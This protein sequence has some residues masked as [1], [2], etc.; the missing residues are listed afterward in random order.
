MDGC[1]RRNPWRVIPLG[2]FVIAVG[3]LRA[4]RGYYAPVEIAFESA[5][6]IGGALWLF[7]YGYYSRICVSPEG[8]R[9]TD[10]FGER[11]SI[12]FKD[13]TA[14]GAYTRHGGKAVNE[15]LQIAWATDGVEVNMNNY[16]RRDMRRLV[17]AIVD[18]TPQV[19]I[20]QSLSDFGLR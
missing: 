13:L 20:A 10:L 16:R 14:I 6:I 11:W 3:A 8:L 7:N 2:I 17:Q 15:N 18:R 19:V 1:I 5:V 9:S 12:G 4:I